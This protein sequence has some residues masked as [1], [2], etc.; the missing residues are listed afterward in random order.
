MIA[1]PTEPMPRPEHLIRITGRVFPSCI[2]FSFSTSL[3]PAIQLDPATPS[4][5]DGLEARFQFSIKKSQ[6][7]VLCHVNRIHAS[8][9]DFLFTSAYETI[10]SAI[11]LMAFSIGNGLTLVLEKA[12]YPDCGF[13]A[14]VNAVPGSR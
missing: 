11:D 8:D 1:L 3:M 12:H 10:R 2:E 4:I 13:R 7:E 5:L 14:N 6:V 9:F